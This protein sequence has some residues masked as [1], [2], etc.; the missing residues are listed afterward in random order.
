MQRLHNWVSAQIADLESD[1]EIDLIEDMAR[2]LNYCYEAFGIKCW[3]IADFCARIREIF[4]VDENADC[5]LLSSIHRM[6][7][8]EADVIYLLNSDNLP[9]ERDDEYQEQ[10]EQNL[11]YIALTRARKKLVFVPSRPVDDKVGGI[12]LLNPIDW[13]QLPK[14]ISSTSN[15]IISQQLTLF[16]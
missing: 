11:L 14:Y 10:E 3:A 4:C 13:S 9:V 1:Y 8:G 15:T 12:W 16:E 5:V 2:A 7:G 6:K